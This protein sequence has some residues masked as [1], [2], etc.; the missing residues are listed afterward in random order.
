[1]MKHWKAFP[2][3]GVIMFVA[4]I[5]LIFSF[6][7]Q[8]IETNAKQIT[9]DAEQAIN[10]PIEQKEKAIMSGYDRGTSTDAYEMA[11]IFVLNTLKAPATAQ[12][13]PFNKRDI[14]TTPGLKWSISGYVDAQNGFG[15]LI[16]S[17]FKVDMTYK[18]N[19]TYRV[20][21]L[22]LSEQ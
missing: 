14:K 5:Y 15:A 9:A 7:Y 16:R 1:M 4:I 20:D 8:P 11:K 10:K 17:W 2:G 19:G 6:T 12:F 18:G 22:R 21:D 13:A 3:V